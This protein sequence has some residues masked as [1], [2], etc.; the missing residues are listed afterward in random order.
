MVQVVDTCTDC[1]PDKLAIHYLSFH[2]KL[3]DP[4]FGEV[5]IRWRQ[6]GDAAV[7]GAGALDAG[8]CRPGQRPCQ[9]RGCSVAPAWPL[10]PAA[11]LQRCHHPRGCM[12]CLPPRC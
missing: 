9:Q 12:P 5:A 7:C 1:P 2:Q 8:A 3:A 10:H 11:S 6:V 4:G